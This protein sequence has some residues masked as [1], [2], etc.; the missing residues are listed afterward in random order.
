MR[1][2]FLSALLGLATVAPAGVIT[3]FTDRATFDAAVG[4]TTVETFADD[5]RFPITTGVLNSATNLVVSSGPAI[6]PGLIQPGATYSSTYIAN[7]DFNIDSGGGFTGGFLDSLNNRPPLVI[8]FTGPVTAIA[9]DTNEL[10]GTAFEIRIAF[11]AGPDFVANPAVAASLGMQF[12]G[13]QSSLQDITSVR[14][15]GNSGTFGY[16]VDNVTFTAPGA[17]GVPEPSSLAL[18]GL[19]AAALALRGLGRRWG[20]G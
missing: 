19:G 10:M 13:Y 17:S 4:A 11:A 18:A 7:T 12:F 8:T 3:S 5:A 15:Q 1:F 14:I 6:V 16:A 9:F 20:R 2:L